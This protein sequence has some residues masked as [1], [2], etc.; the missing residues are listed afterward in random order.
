MKNIKM[1]YP[2]YLKEFKCIGGECE[3]SCCIG[4]DVDID[5]FTFQQYESVSDSDMKNILKSNL[6]KNK[7]CQCDEIDFAKVK[8]GEN[9]RCPFLK[10]DNYCVIHSN[11]GEEYLSNV[12]TSFPR[13]T[14]KIDGIYEMSLAVACPEAARI[15]LLK[16]DGIEF[17]ESDEDLGKHIVSSEVNTKL[18]EEAYLPVEFLKEIRETSIKIMK[19]RKFSLDKR[20]YILGEFINALEDEYE[21]NYHNTLSFIREYDIDTIKDSYEENSMNYVIQVDFFKKLLTMLRVEK[22]I[23][24]DRFKEYSKEVKI[25]LNLD[26]ENYL[27]KNAQMYIKAFEEYEK[28][29]IEENSYI[30]E[31]YI[32]NFIYSNL[33]PLC[34]RESIFDS[35]IMLLIRYTFIRFYLVGMYIYHK[36]NKETLDKALSK[37][38]VVRF[39]QCFSK[40]VEHHKTYLIDL[41]NY[42]K[43][44]DFNNLEFVK[45]LLP[46]LKN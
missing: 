15:L 41:L 43:E 16:K 27:A 6:I 46:A 18:S 34:E 32:V 30:F 29:F 1:R 7:R 9:K 22:D 11:L 8:L 14:N 45:T 3:D 37:E 36:K 21:Y 12:C 23:D 4:W 35:Y 38:E 5:K 24:S 26:E 17:S 13:V 40:V 28:E 44:H 20:L 39:I 31:N 25:G 2:I 33:F 42:I 19:N 10:C